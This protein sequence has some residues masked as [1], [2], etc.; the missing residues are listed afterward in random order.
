[1]IDVKQFFGLTRMVLNDPAWIWFRDP[2]NYS[3]VLAELGLDEGTY[4]DVWDEIMRVF[5]L[6]W[7]RETHAKVK[8]G[9]VATADLHPPMYGW[10]EH[11]P[12]ATFLAIRPY[13]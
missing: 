1:M 10:L 5:P 3:P 6:H 9:Y 4:L 2:Q 8:Q 12:V 7:A 13:G 11:H